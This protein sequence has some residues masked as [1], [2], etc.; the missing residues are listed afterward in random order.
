MLRT[1]EDVLGI[2]PLS[3]YD[4]AQ[5]PMAEVFD[6]KHKKWSFSATPSEALRASALPIPKRRASSKDNARFVFAHDAAWWARQTAGYD[7]SS[8]DRIDA[9]Q[10]DRVLWTGLAGARPYPDHPIGASN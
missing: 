1:I 10:Y 3:I 2:Q 9:E 4:A 7:W 5:Q 6:L 8:E